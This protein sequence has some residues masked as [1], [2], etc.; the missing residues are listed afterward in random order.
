M[1]NKADNRE[2]SNTNKP[3]LD[4]QRDAASP[5]AKRKR[6]RS[7]ADARERLREE[8]ERL[9]TNSVRSGSIV[10]TGYFAGML[11]NAY[12]D[13]GFSVGQIVD[14]ITEEAVRRGI[15]VENLSI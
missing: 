1:L 10:R 9:V 3:G 13:A 15:P 8:I 2:R 12:A 6:R 14:A 5:A 11:A 7:Q 4:D